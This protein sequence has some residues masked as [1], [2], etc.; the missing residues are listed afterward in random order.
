[1][2]K[3]IEK[4]FGK[5]KAGHVSSKKTVTMIA[6]MREGFFFIGD[7]TGAGGGSGIA[8]DSG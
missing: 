7:G 1:M 5:I 3:N 2:E 6:G 4:I 8:G